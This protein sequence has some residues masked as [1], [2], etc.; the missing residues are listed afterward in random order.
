MRLDSGDMNR[1]GVAE[2]KW[3]IFSCS[4]VASA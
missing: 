1:I 2:R 3:Y 4:E